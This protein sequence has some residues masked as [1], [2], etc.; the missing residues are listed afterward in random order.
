[1]KKTTLPFLQNTGRLDTA[2]LLVHWL[3]GWSQV[4]HRY[5]C[6]I[7]APDGSCAC[8]RWVGCDPQVPPGLQLCM[9]IAE[10]LFQTRTH[11]TRHPKRNGVTICLSKLLVTATATLLPGF[12]KPFITYMDCK[13][14]MRSGESSSDKFFLSRPA[15]KGAAQCRNGI[16]SSCSLTTAL[17]KQSHGRVGTLT[18]NSA[19]V[20]GKQTHFPSHSAQVACNNCL[21]QW[22]LLA[23]L[24]IP[25]L[26]SCS[27]V[28]K[29]KL[30]IRGSQQ[31]PYQN[32]LSHQ[33]ALTSSHKHAD[34]FLLLNLGGTRQGVKPLD[35]LLG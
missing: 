23:V 5:K 25:F 8:G 7:L 4:G 15:P 35:G 9:T 26:L 19:C 27:G 12:S 34:T 1:M 24:M 28:K 6:C 2:L 22:H 20:H 13:A 10:G 21:N 16:P 17:R 32:L 14:E 11:L 29:I 33:T 31:F 3:P 30:H 18:S